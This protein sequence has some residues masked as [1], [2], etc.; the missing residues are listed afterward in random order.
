MDFVTEQIKDFAQP[1]NDV[2]AWL[3]SKNKAYKNRWEV[4]YS[5]FKEEQKAKSSAPKK[6]RSL[7]EEIEQRRLEVQRLKSLEGV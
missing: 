6:R 3:A 2:E 7:R 1:I 5:N 4:Y